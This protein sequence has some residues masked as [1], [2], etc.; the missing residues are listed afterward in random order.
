VAD[1]ASTDATPEI[2]ARL[3]RELAGVESLRL[4]RKGRGRA[5]RAAW[6]ASPAR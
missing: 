1:N 2:A 3:A 6:S 5:L 4:E